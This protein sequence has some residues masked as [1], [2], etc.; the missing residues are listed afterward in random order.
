MH[1]LL[2]TVE[3]I[4][5][6]EMFIFWFYMINSSFCKRCEHPLSEF[7]DSLLLTFAYS[8][9]TCGAEMWAPRL[10][11]GGAAKIAHVFMFGSDI[12]TKIKQ[13]MK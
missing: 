8:M 9:H 7:R 5:N 1:H 11:R 13:T 4:R 12:I 2:A 6:F 10:V 3:N